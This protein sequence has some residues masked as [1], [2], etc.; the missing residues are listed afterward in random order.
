MN[1]R[2]VRPLVLLLAAAAAG[3]GCD[4]RDE[5]LRDGGASERRITVTRW[6]TL[7]SA[8]GALQDSLL[9]R[10]YLLAAGDSAVYV[11]DGGSS[12]LLAFGRSDGALRWMSGRRGGGPGEFQRVRDLKLAANA[13]PVLLDVANR[14]ITF[15]DGRGALRDEI[16]LPDVGYA[17]QM[18]PLADGR[19]V[20]L[21]DRPD[22]ALAVVDRGGRVA[23]RVPFP[24]QEFSKLHP[25]V[26]QGS[27]AASRHGESWVF[28][29][30]LGDGWLGF[31]GTRPLR[32]LNP[33]VEPAE[34]PKV[35]TRSEGGTVTTRLASYTPCSGCDISMDGA[36][37]YVLF[38]GLTASRRALLD[39][40]AVESGRYR[41]TFLLPVR[42]TKAAVA[43]GVVYVLV[44][45]PYPAVLALRPRRN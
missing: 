8:G 18:V 9:L 1:R 15:L 33:Y 28:G 30:S 45:E 21:T 6:D 32:D 16:P 34:F 27:L 40:Y 20:L 44:D 43:D 19:V 11:F 12:R 4:R 26:R 10:P 24:W 17:D 39:R 14:R 42:A 13:S 23:E 29:F 35:E 25:L 3:A 41:E 22:S 2:F 38:G 31:R 5:P 7:W 36:D 37:V